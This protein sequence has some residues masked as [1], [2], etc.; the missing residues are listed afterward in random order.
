MTLAL[1]LAQ[2]L[3]CDAE[4]PPCGRCRSCSRIAEGK[5]ADVQVISTTSSD[6]TRAEISIEQIKEMQRQVSLPPYEGRY[7][8]SVLDGAE[9]L[10][11]E[12]A[13]RLLKTLEE[14]PPHIL[15]ILLTS[16]EGLLLPTIIS[17]CQRIELRPM[18]PSRAEQEL[19]EHW[20]IAPQKAKLL[21]RLSKGCLGWALSAEKDDAL[22]QEHSQMM[23]TLVTLNDQGRLARLGFAG[24]LATEFSKNRDLVEAWLT[25]WLGWWHDLLLV[26]GGSIG[27][28]TNI[29][30]ESELARQAERYD[31]RRISTF[32]RNLQAG[33]GQLNQNANPRL[34]LEVLMLNM[35]QAR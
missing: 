7:K 11:D 33:L 10:S 20:N 5:H 17:R 6:R 32:I 8:I 19:A 18:P 3:N 31:L 4:E 14:P 24:K 23:D 21:A 15:I 2:A 27:L 35:P 29:D 22:L 16:K 34:V 13:N 30:R 26:K 9:R 28:I 25:L 1:N 12:A